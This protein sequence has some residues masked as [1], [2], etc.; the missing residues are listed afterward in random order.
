M[1]LLAVTLGKRAPNCPPS[2]PNHSNHCPRIALNAR[3]RISLNAT[4]AQTAQRLVHASLIAARRDGALLNEADAYLL[5]LFD[6]HAAAEANPLR[7]T[8]TESSCPEVAAALAEFEGLWRARATREL[9]RWQAG[10][11]TPTEREVFRTLS[12]AATV[13]EQGRERAAVERQAT[14]LAETEREE[15]LRRWRA[16]K[17]RRADLLNRCEQRSRADAQAIVAK[18]DARSPRRPASALA[19]L[20]GGGAPAAARPTPAAQEEAR[21]LGLLSIGDT[22]ACAAK[23]SEAR[24]RKAETLLEKSGWE[25]YQAYQAARQAEERRARREEEVTQRLV[26]SSPLARPCDGGHF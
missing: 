23:E 15:S 14:A 9:R 8:L 10:K 11:R 21:L 1:R 13:A 24:R 5:G 25:A 12:A 2:A 3:A 19:R 18:Q 16:G 20:P 4:T 7:R 6:L 17:V 22:A 26:A